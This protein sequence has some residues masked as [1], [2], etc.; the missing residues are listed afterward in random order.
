MEG[1]N[2]C[3]K[4]FPSSSMVTFELDL[5]GGVRVFKSWAT[6]V[7]DKKNKTRNGK[8]YS[9]LSPCLE[10]PHETMKS[11]QRILSQSIKRAALSI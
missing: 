2:M 4:Y 6:I 3:R 7:A 10:S 5:K 11:F 8:H 1:I 9:D